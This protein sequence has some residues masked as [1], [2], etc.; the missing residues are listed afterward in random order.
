MATDRGRKDSRV[1]RAM[2]RLARQ[3]AP[4]GSRL[5]IPMPNGLPQSRTRTGWAIRQGRPPSDHP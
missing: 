2:G 4:G 1:V 3:F 5:D